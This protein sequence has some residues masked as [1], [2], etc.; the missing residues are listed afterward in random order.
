MF[1]CLGMSKKK[2][3]GEIRKKPNNYGYKKIKIKIIN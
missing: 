3:L 1:H 2:D